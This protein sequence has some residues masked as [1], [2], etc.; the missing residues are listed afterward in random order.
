M[1]LDF[2]KAL[3]PLL[4]VGGSKRNNEKNLDSFNNKPEYRALLTTRQEGGE[5]VNLQAAN[6]LILLNCWYTVK[7][8]IQILGRVKRKGQKKPVYTYILGYNLFDCIEPKSGKSL[9]ILEE[10]EELYKKIREKAEMCEEWGIKVETKLPPAKVFFNFNT[11]EDEFSAFL[12]NHIIK[13]Q[14]K[15]AYI[16]LDEDEECIYDSKKQA[17]YEKEMQ[18][19]ESYLAYLMYLHSQYMSYFKSKSSTEA[20]NIKRKFTIKIKKPG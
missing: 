15:I 16:E 17:F 20:N 12:D 3:K 13:E 10:E 1:H 8:I 19:G 9:Y 6:H 5:G 4:Y 18:I 14:L 2:M 11:F 7:D